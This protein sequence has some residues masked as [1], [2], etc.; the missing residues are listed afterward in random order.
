MRIDHRRS[1]IALCH[2]R[3]SI[4]IRSAP[5]SLSATRRGGTVYVARPARSILPSRLL[6]PTSYL[7]L[8]FLPSLSDLLDRFPILS[9]ELNFRRGH[10]LFQVRERRRAGD[11]QHHRRSVQQP[12]ERELHDA[13]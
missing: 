4:L 12:R 7:L 8:F 5:A 13:G 11:R 10:V 6:L 9:R 2:P 3:F 1:P